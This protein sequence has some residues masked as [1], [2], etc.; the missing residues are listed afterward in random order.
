[1][2]TEEQVLQEYNELLKLYEF[3]KRIKINSDILSDIIAEIK[4]Y[5]KLLG[6]NRS[7]II[8][9]SFVDNV[10]NLRGLFSVPFIN[11]HNTFKN[12]IPN[13]IGNSLLLDLPICLHRLN[14]GLFGKKINR[15]DLDELR[16]WYSYGV[17]TY[18]DYKS[19]AYML[20]DPENFYFNEDIKNNEDVKGLYFKEVKVC[21]RSRKPFKD[22][23][24]VNT[25]IG[26]EIN[27]QSPKLRLAAK[28]LES[29]TLVELC[30]LK[31]VNM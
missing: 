6:I 30:Q 24:K 12:T 5:E 14:E 11:P 23:N 13:F 19:W 8:E 20:E 21:K 31:P 28:L 17:I 3:K 27:R 2:L 15:D 16:L 22:A 10:G 18:S 4:V 9:L 29:D 7:N 26:I 25:L 1:M